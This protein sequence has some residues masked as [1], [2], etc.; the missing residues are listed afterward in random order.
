MVYTA[1]KTNSYSSNLIKHVKDHSPIKR[2]LAIKNEKSPVQPCCFVNESTKITGHRLISTTVKVL[3]PLDVGIDNKP[4]AIRALL[5]ADA[6][7]SE[8]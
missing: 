8:C 6:H 2:P 7:H 1:V 4:R 3:S 5:L